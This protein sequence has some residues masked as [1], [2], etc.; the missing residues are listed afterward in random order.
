MKNLI[1]NMFNVD[2]K[3][4]DKFDTSNGENGAVEIIIRLKRKERYCPSCGNKL[5]GNGISRKY[6]NHKVLS[7][8][9]SKLI[10][11]ANRYRCRICGHSEYEKIPSH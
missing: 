10:Y 1:M 2:S 4:I 6:I 5:V 9:N 7:D 8:R 3:D 11:E